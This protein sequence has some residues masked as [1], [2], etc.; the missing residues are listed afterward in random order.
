LVALRGKNHDKDKL[1]GAKQTKANRHAKHPKE[2]KGRRGLCTYSRHRSGKT[3]EKGQGGD[4]NN[5]S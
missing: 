4:D 5:R 2:G 1:R 3:P